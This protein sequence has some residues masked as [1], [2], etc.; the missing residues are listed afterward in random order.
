MAY[1]H[2]FVALDDPV[3]LVD[4]FRRLFRIDESERQ[5]THAQPGRKADGVPLRTRDPQGRVRPLH[6]LRHD[7]AAR[8]LE[9]LA[10]IAGVGIHGKHVADLFH[11]LQIDVPLFLHGNAK[12]A[13]FEFRRRFAGA[14]LHASVGHEVERRDHFR[15][16]RRMVVLRD[17]L[18]DSVAEPDV[19]RALRTGGEKHLR[20]G[21]VGV[22]LQ[23]MMFHFPREIDAE[24]IREP[25]L[26]QRLI[27]ELL[28][29][30]LAPRSRQLVFVEDSE[31]HLA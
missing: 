17:D 26:V 8:H 1:W 13:Q 16:A 24:P 3:V 20:R 18:A 9:V 15:R 5:G 23:K 10:L 14:E 29:G 22:L 28:F 27:E 6:R 4:P 7:V 19:L 2:A 11:R 31:F 25:H 21:R 12:T 30:P